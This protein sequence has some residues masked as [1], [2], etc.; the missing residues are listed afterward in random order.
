METVIEGP[1][2]K[3]A[4]LCEPILRSLP[5]WFGIEDAILQYLADI[6]HL[7]TFLAL[8]GDQVIGFL[9]LKQHFPHAA[10]ILVMGCQPDMRRKG[11]GRALVERGE[12]WLLDQGVEYLQVKTLA[13]SHP[14]PGYAKTR[15][16]YQALGFRPL[17]EF[18]QI[19]DEANPCLVLVKKIER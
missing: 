14:D 13:P 15:A 16:F 11:I 9:T 17:E 6:D 7:P 10:E 2:Y 1:S 18:K 19:W 3:K 4:S 12:A 5:D 8:D